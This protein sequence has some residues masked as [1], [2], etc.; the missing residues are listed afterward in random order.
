M[1]H[2]TLVVSPFPAKTW[3]CDDVLLELNF[4]YFLYCPPVDCIIKFSIQK[5]NAMTNAD[6]K[7]LVE[8]LGFY[9]P[10]AIRDHF[11]AIGFNET[12]NIRPIQYWMNGK[13]V[14]LNMPIPEDVIQHFKDLEQKKIELSGMDQFIKNRFIY[15]DKFLMWEK[16]PE[17]NGLPCTF[18]NQLMMLV[19]MLHGHKEM[20]YCSTY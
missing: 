11:K 12:V 6:F 5:E 1:N 14:A 3:L 19:H 10:E 18:L 4:K 13:S 2:T 20:Q 17:L 8:S 15:K 16:F 9:N 7:L